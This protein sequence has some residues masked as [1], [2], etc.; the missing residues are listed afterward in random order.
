M[1][2]RTVWGIAALGLLAATSFWLTR[3]VEQEEQ[4]SIRGL[5]PRLDYA[6]R[7]FEA[8]YFDQQG[9][10]AA[11][12]R[13]P[14]LANDAATGVGRIE[15]PRFE[16]VHE[17]ALWTILSESATLTPDRELVRF[18]GAV[19]VTREE[20][21]ASQPLE[22]QTSEAT[23]EI[24]PRIVRSAAEVAIREGDNTLE[25]TGF[26]LDMLGETFQLDSNVRGR[27]GMP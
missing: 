3:D 21:G 12:V 13:A 20:A 16:I 7:N 8:R 25:A 2:R 27:Y 6:L 9:Q 23:L 24:A 14:V 1:P 18:A 26:R 5:D 22:I 15:A 10:L 17:G 19:S 4:A 11:L